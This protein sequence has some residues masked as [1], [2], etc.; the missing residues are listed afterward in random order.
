MLFLLNDRMLKL[1]E[2]DLI[3]P[4][5]AAHFHRLSLDFVRDLGR[6]VF[7]EHPLLPSAHPGRAARLAALIK[8]K[9]P[10]VNAAL[11][12]A[13]G[14]GCPA[15]MVT[16]RFAEVSSDVMAWLYDQQRSGQLSSVLA[17]REVW[18]RLAA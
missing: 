6:E 15:E 9:A 14:F 16:C 5:D 11:F 12:I 3:A 1:G 4:T 8:V 2:D 7:A 17:D 13:P 10:R 18:R